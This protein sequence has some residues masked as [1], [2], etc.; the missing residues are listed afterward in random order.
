MEAGR[1]LAQR[2]LREGGATPDERITFAFRL[3]LSRLPRPAE[4]KVLL[5]GLA[6]HLETY[7]ADRAAAQKLIRAGA[8]RPDDKL[9]VAELAAYTAVGSLILNLDEAVTKE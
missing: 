4:K 8:S 6:E 2:V 1:A 7:H 5:A 9:D 3:V